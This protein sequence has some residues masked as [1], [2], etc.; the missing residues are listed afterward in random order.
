MVKERKCPSCNHWNKGV[1]THCEKCYSLLDKN[2]ILREEREK[3]YGKPKLEKPG[4]LEN[5]LE[6]TKDTTNPFVKVARFALNVGWIIY[7]A[8]I[9]FIVWLAVGFSG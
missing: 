7:M 8:F 2:E 9:T 1:S 4:W 5:Y 3:I 6:K